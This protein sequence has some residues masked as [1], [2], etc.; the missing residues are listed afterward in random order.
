MARKPWR[1]VQEKVD[2]VAE[3]VALMER[4]EFEFP[5]GKQHWTTANGKREPRVVKKAALVYGGYAAES[6]SAWANIWNE[7]G[8]WHAYYRERLVWHR[9]RL[10]GG[11]KQALAELTEGGGAL[12]HLNKLAYEAL[13]YKLK[14]PEKAAKEFSLRDLKDLYLNSTK[15]EAQL[16]G[17]ASTRREG[18]KE[19]QPSVI[20]EISLNLPESYLDR[21]R[22]KEAELIEGEVEEADAIG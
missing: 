10:S 11:F 1:Q 22:E 16:H 14:E 20:N 7:D 9:Q 3:A 5:D 6:Q 13:V 4:G 19:L 17:E 8:D 2:R 15:L 21:M 18:P 12:R